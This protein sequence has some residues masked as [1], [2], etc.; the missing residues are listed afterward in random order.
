MLNAYDSHISINPILIVHTKHVSSPYCI[1]TSIPYTVCENPNY[2]TW[3]TYEEHHIV[4]WCLLCGKGSPSASHE[5]DVCQKQVTT[6]ASIPHKIHLLLVMS[7]AYVHH[8]FILSIWTAHTT[9]LCSLYCSTAILP[10]TICKNLNYVTSMSYGK[11]HITGVCLFMVRVFHMLC[12]RQT[13]V[14]NRWI[15]PYHMNTI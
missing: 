9:H 10:Y 3:M 14:K 13:Y 2:V 4:C 1:P 5:A 15:H 8:V 7:E 6:T 11:S 12:I